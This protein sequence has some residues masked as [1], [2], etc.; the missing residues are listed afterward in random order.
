MFS[1]IINHRHYDGY[2]VHDEPDKDAQMNDHGHHLRHSVHDDDEINSKRADHRHYD[3]HCVHDEGMMIQFGNHPR[4]DPRHDNEDEGYLINRRA[5]PSHDAIHEVEDNVGNVVKDAR[6]LSLGDDNDGQSIK[7][8]I[9]YLIIYMKGMMKKILM[10]TWG[11][12][13]QMMNKNLF[14]KDILDINLRK[15]SVM[16][17]NIDN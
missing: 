11:I 6:P 9:I 15:L 10:K 14:W 17:I 3:G 12:V 1:L 7:R 13:Y 4:H 8:T 16:V 5:Y 2:C